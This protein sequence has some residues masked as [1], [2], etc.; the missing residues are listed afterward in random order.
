MDERRARVRELLADADDL[1]VRA[2]A[3]AAAV[4]AFEHRR[5]VTLPDEYRRFVLEVADGILADGEPTLYGVVDL[6]ADLAG[7]GDAADAFGHGDDDA[8]AILAAI[9]AVPGGKGVLADPAVHALHRAGRSGGCI[10]LTSGD[11][12]AFS[13]LAITGARRGRMWRTGEVDAPEVGAF[14][15]GGDL[16]PLGFLDWLGPWADNTLG[17]DLTT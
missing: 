11:G 2:P 8:A 9:A 17:L 14:Y 13:A 6:E 3:T 4:A 16:T 12:N 10:T 7:D 15:R 1:V 5:R